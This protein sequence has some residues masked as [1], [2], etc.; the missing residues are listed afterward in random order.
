MQEAGG[1][2]AYC[3][4]PVFAKLLQPHVEDWQ[5]AA[6]EWNRP[7]T[8]LPLHDEE[9]I[10]N[11]PLDIHLLDTENGELAKVRL[12]HWPF[13][14]PQ[15][16]PGPSLAKLIPLHPRFGIGKAMPLQH[17]HVKKLAL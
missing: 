17:K 16:P 3:F 7:R 5:R 4:G 2:A 12:P 14:P 1:F 8:D 15:Q 9:T 6:I 11:P 13:P 10:S